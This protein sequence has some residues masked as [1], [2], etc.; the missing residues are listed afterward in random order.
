MKAGAEI[1]GDAS[2]EE[3]GIEARG[4]EDPRQHRRCRRLA[5]RSGHD[6]D[7]FSAEEFIVQQLWQRA[8]RN[9]LVEDMLEFRIAARDRVAYDNQVGL[10]F[11]ILRVERLSYRDGEI[12]EK[13]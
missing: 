10:E 5:M 1:L 13:I 12:A 11:E 9:A 6:Q 8:E 3:R 7:F 4:V 2:D